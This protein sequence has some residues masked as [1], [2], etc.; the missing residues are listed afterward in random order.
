MSLQNGQHFE[1]SLDPCSL[2]RSRFWGTRI[3]S[4][5]QRSNKS[6]LKTTAW[7]AM[8]HANVNVTSDE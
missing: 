5:P 7:E 2:P 4:S 6:P 1:R 8:T 3:T